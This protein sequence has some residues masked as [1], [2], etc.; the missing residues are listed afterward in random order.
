MT[1]IFDLLIDIN[2]IQSLNNAINV[3]AGQPSPFPGGVFFQ[4]PSTAAPTPTTAPT[5]API[6][7][8]PSQQIFGGEGRQEVVASVP[9]DRSLANNFGLTAAGVD[10][11]QQVLGGFGIPGAGFPGVGLGRT[12]SNL[13]ALN[14]AEAALG[15]PETGVLGELFDFTPSFISGRK[16]LRQRAIDKGD[17]AAR[18]LADK[19]I[20]SGATRGAINAAQKR[21]FGEA[22][23]ARSIS[24]ATSQRARNRARDLE[25]QRAEEANRS[26]SANRAQQE[27]AGREA[28][29]ARTQAARAAEGFG[30]EGR[31]AA[32]RGIG[33][34][35]DFGDR[36]SS[37]GGQGGV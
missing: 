9:I 37:R 16:S 33:G 28:S 17:E 12:F 23:R 24:A 3:P 1:G 8:I 32:D 18:E 36:T 31:Q 15:Q 25:N 10:T 14:A 26:A 29:A 13:N 22:S 34:G 2:D 7:N 30:R 20:Q 6:Q 5:A 35:R 27:R 21:S 4:L 11:A 19:S